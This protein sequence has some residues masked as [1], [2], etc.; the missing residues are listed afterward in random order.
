MI[1]A[2]ST[3]RCPALCPTPTRF[4]RQPIDETS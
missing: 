2:A 1:R 3:A 4:S